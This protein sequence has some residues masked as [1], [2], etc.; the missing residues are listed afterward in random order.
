MLYLAS[1]SPRRHEILK[2]LNIAHEVLIVPTAGADEPIYSGESPL[3][4]AKRTALEKLQRAQAW[5]KDNNYPQHLPVL[6]ADTCVA[7]DNKIL[8]KPEDEAQ[9]RS[10]LQQLSQRTHWVYT[11]QALGANGQI[12]QSL[13]SNKVTFKALDEAE[14][15]AYCATDEP[16]GKAGGYGIQGPASYFIHTLQGRYSAVVGLDIYDLYQLLKQAGLAR[17]C[18]AAR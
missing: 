5:I 18:L 7:L 4:Y 16:F 8:G 2:Q 3:A 11:A 15:E 17:L 12:Y 14:I 9:A 6:C 1:A 13:S 10:F